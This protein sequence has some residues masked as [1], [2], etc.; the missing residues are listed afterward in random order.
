MAEQWAEDHDEDIASDQ[1]PSRAMLTVSSILTI[2]LGLGIVGN[3]AVLVL[4]YLGAMSVPAGYEVPAS[5]LVVGIIMAVGGLLTLV[6]GVLS[7]GARMSWVGAGIGLSIL[8]ALLSLIGMLS[9]GA[10]APMQFKL[11]AGGIIGFCCLT[12]AMA[13]LGRSQ[14]YRYNIWLERQQRLARGQQA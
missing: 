2:L 6:A 11:V 12:A 4:L 1:A 9:A 13:A 14:A 7:L 8:W 10:N 5:L 3:A